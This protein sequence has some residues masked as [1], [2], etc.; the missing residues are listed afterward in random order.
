M[1][2][3]TEVVEVTGCAD[4]V[5]YTKLEQ[6]DYQ[7]CAYPNKQQSCQMHVDIFTTCPL[8][9]AS[10]TIKLKHND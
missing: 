5:M 4:C 10:I 1:T 8:K 2:N 3:P 6:Y 9:K 7:Y